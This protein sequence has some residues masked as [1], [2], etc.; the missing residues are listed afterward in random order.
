MQCLTALAIP[1]L[2]LEQGFFWSLAPLRSLT[3]LCVAGCTGLEHTPDGD[4]FRALQPLRK[5]RTLDISGTAALA[6]TSPPP[7]RHPANH[8][9]GTPPEAQP[10]IPPS[11]AEAL[12]LA[13][14]E[15][16]H[17]GPAA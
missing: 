5:L 15:T 7:S 11:G 2:Q 3:Y 8:G 17:A 12:P 6:F 13:R 16:Q 14:P 10:V 4:T 1:G 9:T